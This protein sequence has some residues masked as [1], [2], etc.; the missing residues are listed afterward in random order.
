M[1]PARPIREEPRLAAIDVR[2]ASESD[3]RGGIID[4]GREIFVP[5]DGFRIRL[6]L[7]LVLHEHGLFALFE[8]LLFRG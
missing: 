6:R 5:R 8:Q 2:N 7:A 3:G 4:A 1:E